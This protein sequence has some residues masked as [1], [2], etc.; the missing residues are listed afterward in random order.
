MSEVW[1]LDPQPACS[2][3]IT[4]TAATHNPASHF[5]RRDI[6]PPIPRPRSANP[7]IGSQEAYT[8][9]SR[10][11]FPV[12]VVVRIVVPMVSVVVAGPVD[13]LGMGLVLKVVVDPEGSPDPTA[14]EMLVL[15]WEFSGMVLTVTA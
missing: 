2:P 11:S 9:P 8:G 15:I 12:M 5:L 3:I 10:C 14:T 4:S 6:L 7:E 13:K 1:R